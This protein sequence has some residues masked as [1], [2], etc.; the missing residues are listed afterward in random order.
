MAWGMRSPETFGQFWPFVDYI[1]WDERLTEYY[2]REMTD[3]ERAIFEDGNGNG[4][5]RYRYYAAQKLVRENGTQLESFP[6]FTDPLPHEVPRLG[7]TDRR[8]NKLGALI[9]LVN[10]VIAI[11][12][13][14]K[15]LIESTD[16]NHHQFFPIYT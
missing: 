11:D 7:R 15:D 9:Q 16:V 4:V 14:L 12:E 3:S 2:E 8:Y 13:K 6:K 5:R 1:G 10:Q